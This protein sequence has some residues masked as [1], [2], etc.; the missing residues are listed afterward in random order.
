MTLI[1]F[2]R[3]WKHYKYRFTPWIAYN[4]MKQAKKVPKNSEYNKK[5][6]CDQLVKLLERF[7]W[8]PYEVAFCRDKNEQK[9]YFSKL[10]RHNQNIMSHICGFELKLAPSTISGA[11]RG[12][13]VKSGK[14]QKGQIACLYP[15]LVYQPWDKILLASI[16]NAYI[17]RC[18][19]GVMLDG[20]PKGLSKYLYKSIHGRDRMN[21]FEPI[22]HVSWMLDDYNYHV[23]PL[24]IGQIV[25]NHKNGLEPPNV[26]YQELDIIHSEEQFSHH[27]LPLL[28]NINYDFQLNHRIK[29]VPLVAVREINENQELFSSYFTLID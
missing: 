22:C 20:K 13:F 17:F 25:N 4:F 8:P 19:D 9:I 11:G 7:E 16:K 28:P 1:I 3:L 6:L 2:K 14:I 26:V 15:G 27:I 12:V 24:N 5:E 21:G 29:L 23:N 18:S 10:H